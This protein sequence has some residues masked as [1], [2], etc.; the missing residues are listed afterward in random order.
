MIVIFKRVIA[1]CYESLNAVSR[2]MT[3]STRVVVQTTVFAAAAAGAAVAFLTLS[4]RIFEF[5]FLR[6]ASWGPLWFAV[7]S[8]ATITLSSLVVGYLLT[9]FSPEAAGSG[10]P[11]LKAA[12]WKELGFVPWRPVLVKFFAGILSLGGGASLGREGP[13][14]FFGGGLAS[15]L[16]GL[17]GFPKRSR[18]LPSLI[19]AAAGLSAAFNAP[20]ASI[21][22]VMEEMI[23]ELGNRFL[24]S[25]V[26][27][28]VA[29]SFVV[30]AFIGRQP[31]FALPEVGNT[32]WRLY[33]L[34]PLVAILSSALG[35]FYQRAVLAWRARIRT[36]SR[37][38]PFLQPVVGG[39]ITWALGCG[40]FLATGHVGV[41]G[42]GYHDLS[43]ALN[44]GLSWQSAGML[45][46]AKF[47]ATV[48][49][50]AWGCCGGIFSPTL[51]F[52]GLTGTFV[53]GIFSLWMPLTPADH[54]VLS[55]VGMTASLG[56]VVQA[57]LTSML[58][59]FEMTHQFLL[60]PPLMLA[61]VV[62]Q[63]IARRMNPQNFYD[64]LL[65]QDGQEITRIKPLRDLENWRNLPVSEIANMRP[66]IITDLAPD[67]LREIL[68]KN[69]YERFPV[70]T[71]G[72]AG[73]L[74]RQEASSAISSGMIP[75]LLKA[76]FCSRDTKISKVSR[77][78]INDPS[79]MAL[80][81]DPASGSIS[82]LVTLH[83][84][85]RV[86]ANLNE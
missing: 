74:T 52:G 11:Q 6:Y 35:A 29:G 5:T 54:V 53:G 49:C 73:I 12:Y 44:D 68:K 39:L 85:V 13:T 24:G 3:S 33:L 50:Y 71:G 86:Q 23:G 7:A 81:G 62:S 56:A 60:V 45:V 48:S 43:T 65:V 84:L 61:V 9:K 18:R 69:A 67:A 32:S 41:F 76:S 40:V 10:I 20:L 75:R 46:I 8:L 72:R 2:G 26:L 51:F 70:L 83:D 38:S 37:I 28:A 80:I 78:L 63:F 19:G 14:V 47:A 66:V 30:H 55:A 42:I 36:K 16:S 64:A 1:G 31:A 21:A 27:A 77:L 25:V 59:V 82:G 34:I 58:I 4:N 15:G 22:F 57:P 79:G 17:W